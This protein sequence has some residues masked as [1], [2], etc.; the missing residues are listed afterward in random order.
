MIDSTIM[1]NKQVYKVPFHQKLLPGSLTK[2]GRILFVSEAQPFPLGE[3]VSIPFKVF[4]S[5]SPVRE[6]VRYPATCVL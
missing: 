6:M 4:T 5:S 3:L 2:L 1:F